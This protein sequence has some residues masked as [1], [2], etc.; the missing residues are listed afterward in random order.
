MPVA[1][2][3]QNTKALL[4]G[5]NPFHNIS[6]L[7]QERT[8]LRD[9]T[10]L[11]PE[12]AADLIL[13]AIDNGANGFMFSVSETTLAIL[14]ALR[15]KERID[16][17][18]LYAIVPYAY[19]YVRLSTQ[20]GGIPGLTKKVV[21]RIV[22]T[23]NLKGLATGFLGFLLTDPERLLKTY[24][25][26]EINKIRAGAGRK[27]KLESVMLHEVITD[28]ALAL[29]LDS[30]FKAHIDYMSRLG[31]TP[32]FNTCNFVYLIDKFREWNIE[33]EQVVI[34]SP[35]N[36]IGFQMTASQEDN[37][38]ALRSLPKP[39]VIAISVLA[40]GYLKPLEALEYISTLP[41]LRGLAIGVSNKSHAIDTFKLVKQKFGK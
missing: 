16:Q 15:E 13:S 19:E 29:N 5:D 30:I 37:E 25:I 6:H 9:K 27:S 34:A 35:F 24:L 8:R 36:K 11:V 28:L 4:V 14:R 7:S 41:N 21:G 10:V 40:A 20:A 17:L 2:I 3:N 33:L 26:Y 18:D 12:S 39:I 23:G 31:V 22:A 38:A 32:G 1:K